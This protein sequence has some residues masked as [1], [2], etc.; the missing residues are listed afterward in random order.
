M[1]QTA[2][3]CSPAQT[4]HCVASRLSGKVVLRDE[5]RQ[6]FSAVQAIVLIRF[7]PLREHKLLLAPASALDPLRAQVGKG[8]TAARIKSTISSL[9][10][11]PPSLHTDGPIPCQKHLVCRS[12]RAPKRRQFQTI[13]LN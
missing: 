8:K 4:A 9:L 7:V 5:K 11:I 6:F 12:S 2:A 1:L 13:K 10:S 3:G